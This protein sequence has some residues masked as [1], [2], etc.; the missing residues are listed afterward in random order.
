MFFFRSVKH[1]IFSICLG[2]MVIVLL[3][4]A[5]TYYRLNKTSQILQDIIRE[6]KNAVEVAVR[7]KRSIGNVERDLYHLLAEKD[8]AEV[9]RLAVS[10]IK[11][12]SLLEEEMQTLIPF[13]KDR[14]ELAEML[15]LNQQMAP[16]RM[17][18]IRA[19]RNL[20]QE[21]ALQGL[22]LLKQDLERIADLSTALTVI[23]QENLSGI[24]KHVKQ[25]T[26]ATSIVLITANL[27]CVI[28]LVLLS[29]A[30]ATS[31]SGSIQDMLHG[32]RS[33]AT[34]DL[35]TWLPTQHALRRRDEVGEMVRSTGKMLGNMSSM[36]KSVISKTTLMQSHIGQINLAA[37]N[38]SHSTETL[39]M[40]SNELKTA[41]SAVS[42][43]METTFNQ[44]DT[45][46]TES[47]ETTMRMKG[48]VAALESI[49]EAFRHFSNDLKNNI[50][51]TKQ[52]T[53]TVD[54]IGIMTRT[55][56]DISSRTNLL[57]LNASIESARAGEQ[58]RGFAVVADEVR[59][60][61]ER[62]SDATKEINLLATQI[63]EQVR[64][65]VECL[66]QSSG[67]I[68]TNL[69]QLVMLTNSVHDT[70]DNA[71]RLREMMRG[72]N[73]E[74]SR[75]QETV[76]RIQRYSSKLFD[77]SQQSSSQ[78]SMLHEVSDVLQTSS[79]ELGGVMQ[80]FKVKN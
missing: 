32:L 16:Q 46:L 59:M 61:A 44:F 27:A 60:L 22:R 19:A 42:D 4:S 56:S 13:F 25:D 26:D 65:S 6:N 1:Q 43:Q 48:D 20:K 21:D 24:A 45:A 71:N 12:S 29:S 55:I 40:V 67:W 37:K 14:Q 79:I 8:M 80:G 68:D 10:S 38:A 18:V 23:A 7:V 17:S 49:Q 73:D 58:G 75:Q 70:C 28:I 50:D 39:F 57:A 36:I 2:T 41:A 72:A 76:A 54:A 30:F 74:I 64:I 62:T 15:N 63:K 66:G 78:A 5:Y 9:R 3:S 52:L 11:N 77:L 69:D 51:T 35:T 31:I 47:V 34:G 33:M 53:Q